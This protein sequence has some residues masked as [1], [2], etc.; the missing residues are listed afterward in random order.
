[1]DLHVEVGCRSRA[2]NAMIGEGGQRPRPSWVGFET[3]T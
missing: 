3:E 1:M 2:V